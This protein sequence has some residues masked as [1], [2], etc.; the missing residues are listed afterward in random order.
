MTTNALPT[1]WRSSRIPDEMRDS[2]ALR[3]D[4]Q[5]TRKVE[6]LVAVRLARVV[7]VSPAST[8]RRNG[9]GGIRAHGPP[10]GDNSIGNRA[11]S[12]AIPHNNG[13]PR[14]GGIQG[15]LNLASAVVRPSGSGA[16]QC[17]S[18]HE[19][20]SKVSR[21]GKTVAARPERACWPTLEGL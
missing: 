3:K 21:A 6:G 8:G 2:A 14:P 20:E 4:G 11:E 9:G 5:G 15:G 16:R 12:T 17:C 13:S 10:T 7:E 18:H 1:R 19:Y